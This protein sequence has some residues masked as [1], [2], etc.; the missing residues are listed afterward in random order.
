VQ[1]QVPAPRTLAA[2]EGIVFDPRDGG[3]TS[4]SGAGGNQVDDGDADGVDATRVKAQALA[5]AAAQEDDRQRGRHT[6]RTATATAS[7]ASTAADV[8][9]SDDEDDEDD[10][11]VDG[12]DARALLR[13]QVLAH[14]FHDAIRTG[15]PGPPTDEPLSLWEGRLPHAANRRFEVGMRVQANYKAVGRCTEPF[16]NC[17][18]LGL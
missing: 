6:T 16:Y 8:A 11:D 17:P 12:P 9:A 13:D 4:N 14:I 2:I 7:T 3:S 15:V 18:Y 5:L 10:E 1:A